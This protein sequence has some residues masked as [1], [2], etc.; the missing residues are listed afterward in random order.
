M[1]GFKK[2]LCKEQKMDELSSQMR[3]KIQRLKVIL[4]KQTK[5]EQRS[6]WL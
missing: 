4:L 5:P 2:D 3:N 1:F 6:Q